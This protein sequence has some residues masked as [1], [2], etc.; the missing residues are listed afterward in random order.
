[1]V[2]GFFSHE[3]PETS[4]EAAE[5]ARWRPPPWMQAP[6]DELPAVLATPHIL[7]R[8]DRV[9]V[10]FSTVEVFSVGVRIPIEYVARRR[11][12]AEL[13]WQVTL[14]G[15]HGSYSARPDALRLGVELADGVRLGTHLEPHQPFTEEQPATP[16]LVS[17]GFGG[18]GGPDEWRGTSGV[19][20]WPLPP[21]GKLDV[22]AEWLALGLPESR[23]TLDATAIRV[24]AADARQLW[25]D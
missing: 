19:W 14:H 23:V 7:G 4:P 11:D 16:T 24:A 8:S 12:E 13:E 21:P 22:V 25:A 2:S 18:G 1:M 6:D 17:H 20:L 15:L 5:R 10:F 3:L 9:V